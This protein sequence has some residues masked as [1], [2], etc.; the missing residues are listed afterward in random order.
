[1]T[2]T[3][4]ADWAKIQCWIHEV[5]EDYI[6]VTYRHAFAK[7]VSRLAKDHFYGMAGKIRKGDYQ[8]YVLSCMYM[9]SC[10]ACHHPL[11]LGDLH[12][13]CDRSYTKDKIVQI[14]HMF[15]SWMSPSC[16]FNHEMVHFRKRIA[17]NEGTTCDLVTYE[18][19]DELFV[20][21]R[22]EHQGH[23]PAYDAMVEVFVHY[24]LEDTTNIARLVGV[25]ITET[26]T[27]LYYEYVPTPLDS[28]FGDIDDPSVLHSLTESLLHGVKHMH[29]LG[30]AHRDLKGMNVHVT[31]DHQCM[32]LDVGS[33][34]YGDKRNTIPICTISHRSP[35][36]L[37]AEIEGV[38]YTYDGTCLD[39]WSIGVLLAE[40]YMG[41]EPF[42]RIPRGTSAKYMLA[43]IHQSKESVLETL[44]DLC[45][46]TQMAMIRRCLDDIPTNRPTIEEMVKAFRVI[47]V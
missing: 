11:G 3:R 47:H 44:Q 22:I 8:A 45:T 18:S 13:L 43:R 16:L 37:Q 17:A 36:L 9:V 6:A 5:T 4:D 14:L 10:Y 42:G 12:T 21:K 32:I 38:P 35:D 34:G 31:P 25:N 23:M 39:M 46:V 1:M 26:Y 15:V 28:Y 19:T 41:P 29:S 2:L 33:A 30:I 27:N 40:I 24:L 7:L 20:R